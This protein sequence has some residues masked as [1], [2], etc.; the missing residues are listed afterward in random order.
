MRRPAGTPAANRIV[1]PLL[2]GSRA[3]RPAGH[4]P[5]VT[6]DN[7]GAVLEAPEKAVRA[8]EHQPTDPRALTVLSDLDTGA[9]VEIPRRVRSA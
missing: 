6:G 9:D 5:V 8:P 1:A 3:D 7:A 2:S 4:L